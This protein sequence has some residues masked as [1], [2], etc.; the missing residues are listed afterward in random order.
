MIFL[1]RPQFSPTKKKR[2]FLKMVLAAWCKQPD[3]AF[4]AD[5]HRQSSALARTLTAIVRAI[6]GP[7]RQSPA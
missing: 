7:Y 4:C 5:P 6:A 3:F 2:L 1:K